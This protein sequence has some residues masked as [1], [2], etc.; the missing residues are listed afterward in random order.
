[1]PL[2][3]LY[4]DGSCTEAEVCLGL[5]YRPENAVTV[6]MAAVSGPNGKVLLWVE[7]VQST[8]DAAVV[9]SSVSSD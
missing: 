7:A 8:C 2:L 3:L 4:E 9:A 6:Q 5:N 1:M